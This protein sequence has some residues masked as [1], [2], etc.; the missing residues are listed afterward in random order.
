[1]PPEGASLLLYAAFLR[2]LSDA[3][4]ARATGM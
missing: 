4:E 1:M 2:G 3:Q